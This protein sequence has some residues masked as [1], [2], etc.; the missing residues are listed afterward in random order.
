[1]RGLIKSILILLVL[2]DIVFAKTISGVGLGKTEV[3]AREMALKDLS[4]NI[5]VDVESESNSFSRETEDEFNLD[6]KVMINSFSKNFLLG[7]KYEVQKMNS[8]YKV[9]AILDD[10]SFMIYRHNI[11]KIDREIDELYSYDG[12]I[13][14]RFTNLNEITSKLGE[15]K[16]LED[17]LDYVGVKGTVKNK[18]TLGK[19][20]REI[21]QLTKKLSVRKKIYLDLKGE[22][23]E[24]ERKSILNSIKRE[25]KDNRLILSADDKGIDYY[26]DIEILE[27]EKKI[28]PKTTLKP[29]RYITT[30]N[31]NLTVVNEESGKEVF[32]KTISNKVEG[33]NQKTAADEVKKSLG[34]QIF[35]EINNNLL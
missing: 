16:K 30:Y 15:R 7:V 17:V 22:V 11:E 19:V 6:N 29:Q 9:K 10:E 20:K 26:V 28:V 1:M 3:V 2:S 24:S 4:D 12:D 5:S 31:C 14:E 13:K 35:K 8:S 27:M 23:K 18:L 32:S 21:S 34:V 33:Y 25:S